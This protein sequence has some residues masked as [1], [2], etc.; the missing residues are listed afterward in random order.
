LVAVFIIDAGVTVVVNIL[1]LGVAAEVFVFIAFNVRIVVVTEVVV[2]AMVM[3]AFMVGLVCCYC[4]SCCS[5][6]ACCF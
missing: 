5:R 2:V 3:A 1:A 6:C 4:G